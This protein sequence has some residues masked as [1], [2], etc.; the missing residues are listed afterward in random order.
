MN[1][2][3]PDCATCRWSLPKEQEARCMWDCQP[4]VGAGCTKHNLKSWIS[5][6]AMQQAEEQC[7]GCMFKLSPPHS[8]LSE[9][10]PAPGVVCSARRIRQAAHAKVGR[11]VSVP[12]TPGRARQFR[13]RD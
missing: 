2:R 3:H 9:K 8:C 7:K 4:D 11:E 10:Q 6:K 1:L 13:L 5:Q 12:G